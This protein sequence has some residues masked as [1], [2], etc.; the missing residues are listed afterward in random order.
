MNN[1]DRMMGDYH[2]DKPTGK[3]VMLARNGD[4]NA[5]NY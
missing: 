4:V 2:N 3:H 5:Y 1:G